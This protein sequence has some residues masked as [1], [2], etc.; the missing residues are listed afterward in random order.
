MI[1]NTLQEPEW[2]L[3]RT[4]AYEFGKTLQKSTVKLINSLNKTLK[5]YYF[6]KLRKIKPIF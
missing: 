2:Y 1:Q 6:V 4:S 3:A 5:K